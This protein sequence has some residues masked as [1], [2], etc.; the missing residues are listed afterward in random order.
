[1]SSRQY[2]IRRVANVYLAKSAS[3]GLDSE[4]A[5][6]IKQGQKFLAKINQ[7]ILSK[8]DPLKDVSDEELR[9]VLSYVTL[10][11]EN[12]VMEKGNHLNY[13]GALLA[14]DTGTFPDRSSLENAFVDQAN[15]LGILGAKLVFEGNKVHIDS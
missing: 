11:R 3:I 5:K 9:A 2:Q 13:E 12:P 7:N 1:M 8:K 15:R 10:K 4:S 14:K 6:Q